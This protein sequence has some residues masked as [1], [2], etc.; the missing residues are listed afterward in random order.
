MAHDDRS[1]KVTHAELVARAERWLRN[2]KKCGVV[3]AERRGGTGHEIPDA[4]GWRVGVWSILVECKASRADF[5]RDAKK[6]FRRN[7][8]MGMGQFRFYMTPPGL[9]LTSDELPKGWGLVEVHDRTVK[10]IVESTHN[11]LDIERCRWELA[12][13]VSA[14]RRVQL[15]CEPTVG[16]ATEKPTFQASPA[17]DRAAELPPRPSFP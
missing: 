10:V 2:T 5:L 7:P 1:T 3:F 16:I 13:L 4:I 6:L 11:G 17:L 15:G 9:V 12:F 8:E 14:M